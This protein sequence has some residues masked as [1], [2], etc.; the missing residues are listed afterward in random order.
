MKGIGQFIN[1]YV[2]AFLLGPAI[3]GMW[4]GVRIVLGY[5]ANAGLGAIEGMQREVPLLHGKGEGE[6]AKTIT[7]ISFFFNFAV[8][9]ILAA[10]LMAAT[11]FIAASQE[12]LLALRFASV[13]LVL[14]SFKIFYETLLKANKEFGI[15]SIAAVIDGMGFLISAVLIFYFSFLGFL[16]GF[17]ATMFI[18]TA[19]AAWKSKYFAM[20]WDRKIL[21]RLISIGFPIMLIGFSGI[22]FQTIDRLLILGFLGPVSLGIYSLGALVFMPFTFV[23]YT[24]NS[25]M[26]PH[27]SERF[28]EMGTDG[29]LKNMLMIPLHNLSLVTPV[30]IGAIAVILPTVV[31]VFLPAYKEGVGAA[32]IFL[33]GSF[34]VSTVGMVANFF[35]ATNRQMIYLFILIVSMVFNA[36]ASFILL[37]LGYGIIGAAIGAAS[38]YIV[39]FVT[40][41][42]LSF[43]YFHIPSRELAGWLGG[44]LFPVAYTITASLLVLWLIKTEGSSEEEAVRNMFMREG[45]FFLLNSYFIYKA[46]KTIQTLFRKSSL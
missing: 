6:T 15:L 41:I 26:F 20:Q 2:A 46:A 14:Q 13:L 28:G 11:F 32:T 19:Y 44:F 38:S 33:F 24:A 8:S 43:R 42:T 35:I 3:F 25:V 1:Q 45:L 36:V 40:M 7:G 27:F 21:L 30:A 4:Q 16:G 9:F 37:S 12:T 5:G 18:S 23:L 22:G 39:F 10:L 29:S 17:T 31:S 34:F